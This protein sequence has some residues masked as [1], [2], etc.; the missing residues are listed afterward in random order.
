MAE[1][2]PVR[3]THCGAVLAKPDGG[4]VKLRLRLIAFNAAGDATAPCPRCRRD[5]KLPLTLG[6]R[7]RPLP[8]PP[9]LTLGG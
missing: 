4:K 8:A 9:A 2:S 6:H 3:C 7:H 1:A 5:T